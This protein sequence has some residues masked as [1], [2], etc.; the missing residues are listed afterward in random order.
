MGLAWTVFRY[1]VFSAVALTA[2][3]ALSVMAVQ[4]RKLNPFGRAARTI[5]RLTDPVLKPIERRV[6]RAGGNPQQAPWWMIGV[7]VLGGIVLISA[8][9]W[10]IRQTHMV[11]AAAQ[12]GGRSLIYLL[13]SWSF[14]LLTISLLIRVIGSWFGIGPYTKWMKPFYLL[15]E[16]FLAPMRRV[17]PQLGPLD[18]SPL[19]AWLLI[20]WVLR[21]AVLG[22][23]R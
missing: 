4:R 12:G 8:A 5:R 9:E 21:P 18:I 11:A 6:L 13:V 16:W 17:L 7:S 3:A 10:G 2:V 22:L 15:T 23:L 14:S 1:A 20:D 19:V